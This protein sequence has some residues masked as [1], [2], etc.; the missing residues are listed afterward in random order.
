MNRLQPEYQLQC[1][2]ADLL[3]LQGREGL[4]WFHVPNGEHRSPRT[5]ARLKRMGTKRGVGDLI[6][7]WEGRAI[8]L[9]LKADKHSYQ[10]KEQR[11]FEREWILAGGLYKVCKSYA[12][13][14]DFLSLLDCI[15]PI[16]DGRFIPRE[17][18]PAR[19]GAG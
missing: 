3:R 13:V 4:C 14:V 18:A 8:A 15:K 16:R 17:I 11:D 1:L 10:S 12:E 6:L 5:G 2:V 9:E 7:L 19:V